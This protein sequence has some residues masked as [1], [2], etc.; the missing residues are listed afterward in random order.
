MA[1]FLTV[2]LQEKRLV[3]DVSDT[4]GVHW[5][6]GEVLRTPRKPHSGKKGPHTFA[7]AFLQLRQAFRVTDSGTLRRFDDAVEPLML[8]EVLLL[9]ESSGR[10]GS[11]LPELPVLSDVDWLGLLGDALLSPKDGRI[12]RKDIIVGRC[13]RLMSYR[14]RIEW[15]Q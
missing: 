14:S 1:R 10:R 3:A 12:L 5:G 4:R 8:P 9:P 7:R 11:L 13:L 6:G 15:C 2:T